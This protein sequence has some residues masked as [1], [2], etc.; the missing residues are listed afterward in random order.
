VQRYP[1]RLNEAINHRF[2]ENLEILLVTPR[3]DVCALRL[4]SRITSGRKHRTNLPGN[5]TGVI[6]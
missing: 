5:R 4:N 2:L 6:S 3:F 1:G